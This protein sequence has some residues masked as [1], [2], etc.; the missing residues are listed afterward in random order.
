MLAACFADTE[1]QS[2]FY[3]CT[4]GTKSN[5]IFNDPESYLRTKLCGATKCMLDQKT[6]KLIAANVC[7][8]DVEL[9]TKPV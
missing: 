2:Y 5:E 9:N 8:K 4:Y 3:V 6:G 1:K 7:T